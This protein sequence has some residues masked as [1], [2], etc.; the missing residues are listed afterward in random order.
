MAS[1]EENWFEAIRKSLKEV[2]CLSSSHK[3]T[4]VLF[5]GSG[6]YGAGEALKLA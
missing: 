3:K 5:H 6:K 2:R 1:P 4:Q